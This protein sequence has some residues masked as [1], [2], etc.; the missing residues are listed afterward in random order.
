MPLGG[1]TAGWNENAPAN[2]DSAG[3]GDDEIRSAKSNLRGALDSEHN[4]PSTGGANTGY[5]RLGSAR[6]FVEPASRVSSTGTDGRLIF[7]STDS[8]FWNSGAAAASLLGGP[9]VLMAT[10]AGN[11][12]SQTSGAPNKFY[13]LVQ[14]GSFI[15]NGTS[16]ASNVTFA[17]AYSGTPVV[18]LLPIASTVS[19][20]GTDYVAV[21]KLSAVNA[22]GFSAKIGRADAV[23]TYFGTALQCQ[24]ISIGTAYS[25]VA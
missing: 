24:W 15:H 11:A 12:P 16:S 9:Q 23:A 13:N 6:P 14:W 4:F 20:S 3:N 21:P 10:V 5:H 7:N 1:I 25:G 19:M 18:F 8:T 2:T 22:S 17:S